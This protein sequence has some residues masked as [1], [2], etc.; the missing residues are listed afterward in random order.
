MEREQ[1]IKALECCASEEYVCAQCPIDEKI[2]DDCE[3][4][5]LVVKNALSL[6]KE[7]TEENERLRAEWI[8]VKDRL[9]D[10]Y[11]SV[12]VVAEGTSISGGRI[13]AIGSYGGGCWSMADADGTMRLTKYMQ[14]I[15]TH[16][17][18]LPQIPKGE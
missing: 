9:P 10:N 5:K 17:K 11:R 6:I 16:W 18:E 4:G 3:C 14:Y 7:L 2:K 8:S 12:L 13:R 1:I 15:V